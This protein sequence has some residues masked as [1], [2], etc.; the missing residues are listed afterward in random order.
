MKSEKYKGVRYVETK[1]ARYK[2]FKKKWRAALTVR[3]IRWQCCYLTEREAATGYDMRLI[4]YGLDPVNILK[5][6]Q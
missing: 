6:K 1:N 3:G 2:N 4:K 5:R